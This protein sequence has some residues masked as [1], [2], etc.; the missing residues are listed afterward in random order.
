MV[1]GVT[2]RVRCVWSAILDKCGLS[3][4]LHY[5]L[6]FSKRKVKLRELHS[7]FTDLQFHSLLQCIEGE[8]NVCTVLVHSLSARC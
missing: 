2:I 4:I 6:Y 7:P 8:T 3:S 5:M 1:H